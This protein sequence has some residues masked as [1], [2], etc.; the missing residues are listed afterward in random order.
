VALP[1]EILIPPPK[2]VHV[3]ETAVLTPLTESNH[4]VAKPDSRPARGVT[5]RVTELRQITT[6]M[7]PDLHKHQVLKRATH[8]RTCATDIAISERDIFK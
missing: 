1:I 3:T 7:R 4:V 6:E 8:M 5:E 2:Y